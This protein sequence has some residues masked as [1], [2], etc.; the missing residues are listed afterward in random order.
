MADVCIP[1][2]VCLPYKTV[3]S[4]GLQ[5]Q[6]GI[7]TPV[8]SE[9]GLGSNTCMMHILHGGLGEDCIRCM[10]FWRIVADETLD[11]G[12]TTLR[13]MGKPLGATFIGISILVL[14]IGVNRFVFR[15]IILRSG[16]RGSLWKAG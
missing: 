10:Y 11:V 9:L 4:K 2:W 16:P 7:Q 12:F 6:P 3:L 8:I 15:F 5:R 13:H 14:M 1:N